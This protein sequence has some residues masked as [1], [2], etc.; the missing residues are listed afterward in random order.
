MTRI[1]AISIFLLVTMPVCA[2]TS[3]SEARQSEKPIEIDG[4]VKARL[5][6]VRNLPIQPHEKVGELYH[7]YPI[8]GSTEIVSHSAIL[9]IIGVLN[10]EIIPSVPDHCMFDARY[11]LR[12]TYEA[13]TI[14]YIFSSHC[15]HGME[16][17]GDKLKR[18][19]SLRQPG[20]SAKVLDQYLQN[21]SQSLSTPKVADSPMVSLSKIFHGARRPKVEAL[22]GKW[23]LV[24]RITTEEFNSGREGQDI[25]KADPSGLRLQRVPG[26]PLDWELNL[27]SGAS[28]H[29][30]DLND[31]HAS[32][33]LDSKGELTIEKDYGGD[34]L[35]TYRCRSA[36]SHLVCLLTGF[37]NGSGLEFAR[38]EPK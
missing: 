12:I 13:K 4:L 16:Y 37:E 29:L 26:H 8:T 15:S 9:G 18:T 35:S 31:R 33:Y 28:G 17:D 25:V 21:S 38:E 23:I 27:S 6:S 22:V 1:A 20:S 34:H 7:F 3:A 19:F 5:Y 14:D 24:S 11:G 30:E 2:A 10:Q 32:I 36:S